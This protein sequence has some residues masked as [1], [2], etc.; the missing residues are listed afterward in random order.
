MSGNKSVKCYDCDGKGSVVAH[1]GREYE[2]CQKCQGF[3][4]ILIDAI[5]RQVLPR[6]EK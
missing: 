6:K 4:I 1:N 3:G 5:G 2:P